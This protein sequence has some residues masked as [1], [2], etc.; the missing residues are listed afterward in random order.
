MLFGV[1]LVVLSGFESIFSDSVVP[2]LFE[3]SLL[4]AGISVSRVVVSSGAEIAGISAVPRL[5]SNSALS[6]PMGY[7]GT[8]F[9]ILEVS[10][11]AGSM[12]SVST[13]GSFGGGVASC[14]EIARKA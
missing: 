6:V 13:P 9:V 4:S 1:A 11:F 8:L 3:P 7:K 14:G 2:G 12:T 10:T 5:F